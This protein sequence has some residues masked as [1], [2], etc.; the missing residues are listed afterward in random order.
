MQVFIL[1]AFLAGLAGSIHCVGMC[2][3]LALSLP[4]S[5]FSKYQKWLAIILYNLGRVGAYSTIGLI[6]GLLGRGINWFGLT[7]IISIV[8][9]AIIL[10][11]V[12]LPRLLKKKSIHMPAWINRYQ[13]NAL[14]YLMKK[15]TVGWMFLV[16]IMNGFL[17]CGL[18]YMAVAAALVAGSVGNAML[19]MIFFGIG[20]IPAMVALVA[21]AQNMPLHIRVS[22]QKFVPI[23]SMIIGALLILR[24]L[25]LDIPFISPYLS[26]NLTGATVVECHTP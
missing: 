20:T 4:F 23:V 6:V 14:Q 26:Q 7:Q 22:F 9:G 1:T 25:N 16:G 11:S 21:I 17:P 13:I 19:F 8:L 10:V 3:P 15:Q 2:G 24:G 18:V 5:R 12:V